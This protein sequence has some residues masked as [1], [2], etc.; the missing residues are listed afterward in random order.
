M[1]M[2]LAVNAHAEITYLFVDPSL[3]QA[4]NSVKVALGPVTKEASNPLFGEG[5]SKGGMP[6]EL[7]WW[8]TYPTLAF[9]TAEQKYKMW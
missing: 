4:T 1:L 7:A 9:D 3:L 2:L 8:N 6:W 5:G